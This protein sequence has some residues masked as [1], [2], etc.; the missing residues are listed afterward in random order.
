VKVPILDLKPAYDELRADLDAAYHRVMASGWVL[1]GK[2]LEAF[3]AEYARS[4]G[5]QHC[6]GVANGLEAL[7]LVLMARGIGAGD[8]VI[9]PSH[10][11]IATFLAVTHCGARPVPCEP[12]LDTYN[13]DPQRLATLITRRT[14]AIL[15]IHLYGQ[16]ADMA[17]INAVAAKHHLLVLEDAAQ[18]HGAAAF[19]GQAGGLGHAAGVSFYPSKNLGALAD[20]GAVTTN[21]GQLADKIRHLRNYG[22]K[23]RYHN[24]YIGLNSRLSELQAA[25]LRAKLPHL[26]AWNARRIRLATRYFDALRGVGDIVLPFV[27]N[28]AQPVWHLFVIRSRRRDALQAFLASREIGTQVHYPIPPHLS[29]AYRSAGWKPGDF[30]LAEQLANEV[31]SLPIGPHHTADQIDYV[32]GAIKE[33]FRKPQA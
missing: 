32:C 8:E 28:W 27:P 25:F 24:E 15:P 9:V 30:P 10:G 26:D 14:K 31:L 1:L 7:Q 29:G 5:V 16:P 12:D 19:G 18:S 23:V 33:F 17:A 4:V 3:E 6:V 11:Y 13:L 22:S 20:A 2:E 21:D